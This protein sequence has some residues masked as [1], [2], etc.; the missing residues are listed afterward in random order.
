MDFGVLGSLVI[1]REGHEVTLGSPAQRRIL[2]ALLVHSGAVVSNDRL[3]AAVWDENPPDTAVRSLFVYISRLRGLLHSQGDEVLITRPPGY[4]LEIGAEHTDAGRFERLLGEARSLTTDVPETALILLDEALALWRGGA[5]AEFADAEF[6]KHEA[7]RLEE[8]RLAAIEAKQDAGLVLGH[9][10]DL[11]GV[12]E[13]HASRH[14]LRERPRSQ[15]MLALYRCQRHAEALAVFREFRRELDD[16]LGIEPSSRLRLLESAILRQ[17]PELDWTAPPS[18]IGSNVDADA[19]PPRSH[20]VLPSHALHLIGRDQDVGATAEAL[21]EYRAVTLTGVGGVGKTQLALRV[22]NSVA[23]QYA[24]GVRWCDLA[25]IT[26]GAAVADALAAAVGARRQPGWTVEQSVVAV[27]APRHLLLA[28]DNCEHVLEAVAPLLE[29][30]IRECPRVTLLCTSRVGLGVTGE[31]LRP[32]APLPVPRPDAGAAAAGSPAVRLF[33]DRAQA[34][35][36]D[37]T[38]T[39]ENLTHIAELCRQLDGLPLGIELAAARTRSLNPVDLAARSADRF[40]LLTTART[41]VAPRHR[42]LRAVVDWSYALLALPSSAY[43]LGCPSSPEASHWTQLN[44]SAKS[45]RCSTCWQ[46]WWRTHWCRLGS[47][48]AQSDT[49][50]WKRCARTAVNS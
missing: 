50:C 1:R 17:D 27:L 13:A 30:V 38:L 39:G 19:A 6:A 22:A 32:I 18:R 20:G 16:E 2:A 24:D 49:R 3:I 21:Y 14:P 8:L 9:H 7:M 37:F 25:P 28:V 12:I 44:T 35:R 40:G 45:L 46:R 48:G 5:Y 10:A 23:R 29:A 34:V 4:V 42:T 11:V 26:D 33:I 43:S 47:Q 36:P 15:L 31:R 41:S